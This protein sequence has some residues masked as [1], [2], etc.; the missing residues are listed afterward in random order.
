MV[1]IANRL[2]YGG[3]VRRNLELTI[4]IGLY[5]SYNFKTNFQ[6]LIFYNDI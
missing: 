5:I 4:F 1:E 3:R 6:I 2:H